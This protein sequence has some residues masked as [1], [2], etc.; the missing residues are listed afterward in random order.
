MKNKKVL[1]LDMDATTLDDEKR[2]SKENMEALKRA[3]EAGHEV[4]IATGRT[5]ASAGALREKYRLKE[6]G[7]RYMI[8]FNGAAILD[9]ETGELLYSRTIPTEYAK[10]LVDA[11]R[12]ENIYLHTYTEDKVLTETEDENLEFYLKRT[13]M[14][15]K[16]VPDLK[17]ALEVPPYKLLAVD[18][19]S[20]ERLEAFK[21]KMSAWSRGKVDMYFSCREYLEI[22]SE[23]VCK[24][25]AL[26]RF[27]ELMDIPVENTVAAGDECNDISMIRAAGTGCAV[28]NALAEIKEAADYV[29]ERDNNHSAVAE[30]VERFL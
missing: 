17:Q 30:I 19:R 5:H 18:I 14:S 13:G 10:E 29:T 27:C 11:A 2:I 7:C 1:F 25:A 26:L 24:G 3:Y 28:A 21:E 12:R 9:C 16:L 6:I 8:V 4:V 20:V 23:G 22:V 15:A